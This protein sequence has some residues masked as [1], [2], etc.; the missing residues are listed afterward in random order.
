LTGAVVLLGLSP[1]LVAHAS[2]VAAEQL[3]HP[4]R[5]IAATGLSR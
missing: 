4:A 1:N 5:Y 2:A 3:L